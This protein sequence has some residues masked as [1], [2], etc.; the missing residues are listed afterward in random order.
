[1]KLLLKVLF[2]LASICSLSLVVYHQDEYY[3]H[4][5][6]LI[7]GLVILFL[8]IVATLRGANHKVFNLLGLLLFLYTLYFWLTTPVRALLIVSIIAL[9]IN[10]LLG[11]VKVHK[12][13]PAPV[14][15]ATMAKAAPSKTGRKKP[16]PKPGSKRKKSAS[17]KKPGPK[18]GSKRKEPT[19]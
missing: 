11:K 13:K 9:I 1:M 16:G 4:Y 3:V 18:K 15:R 17:R 2:L 14:R 10:C 8:G 5:V 19:A 6:A 12:K 7:L